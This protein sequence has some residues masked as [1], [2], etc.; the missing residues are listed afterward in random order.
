MMHARRGR[1]HGADL[2]PQKGFVEKEA[3]Q[4]GRAGDAEAVRAL[5][6]HSGREKRQLGNPDN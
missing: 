1:H 4:A 3:G 2:G 5:I 6:P